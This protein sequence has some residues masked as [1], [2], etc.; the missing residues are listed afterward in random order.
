M[1][2]DYLMKNYYAHYR[3]EI[4]IE[5]T[6]EQVDAVLLHHPEKI[7]IVKDKEIRGIGVFVTLTDETYKRIELLDI[8]RID[9]LQALALENGNNVHFLLLC[10]DSLRT[11]LT[12]LHRVIDIHRPK[13]LS[14]WN[15]SFNKLHR[16]NLCHQ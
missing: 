16:Y 8:K 9:V 7:I 5:P 12:G 4:P 6:K 14:W 10:A 15:P 3:G 1:I 13:T 2:Y 11:I